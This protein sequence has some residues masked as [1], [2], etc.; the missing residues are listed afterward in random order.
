M[1]ELDTP[2]MPPARSAKS[3]LGMIGIAVAAMLGGAGG[4]AG[5]V[6]ATKGLGAATAA[7]A[8]AKPKPVPPTFVE[9]PRPF[10]A[11]LRDSGRYVQ[12]S[13]GLAVTGGT[14]AVEDL[15]QRDVALRSAVLETLA[16]QSDADLAEPAG[17]RRLRSALVK[18]LNDVIKRTGAD[19]AISDAYFTAFVV[20]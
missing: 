12:L 5:V 7:T 3:M 10:T 16:G 17:K 14:S 4:G 20:Q 15:K 8:E 19:Y 6:W 2:A 18:A 13:L 1:P 9:L 11:N